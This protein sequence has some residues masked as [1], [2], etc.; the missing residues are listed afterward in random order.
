MNDNDLLVDIYYNKKNYDGLENLYKKAKITNKNITRAF[1]KEWL[2]KQS[3][4]QESNKHAKKKIFLPIYSETPF[5]FQIDLTFFPRYKKQ[6]YN[7]YVLFTAININTRYAYAYYSK[8]KDMEAVLDMMKQF[9]RDALEINAITTDE[10]REFNNNEFL[11][12]C[13]EQDIDVF[14]VK[15]DSHKLGIVNRFHR[16]LKNKLLKHF[17][18]NDTVN[19]VDVIKDVIYNYNHTVN[20]GIG[21]EPYKVNSFIEAEIVAEKKEKTDLINENNLSINIGDKCRIK[22]KDVLFEDKMTTKYSKTVYTIMKVNKNSVEIT[23]NDDDLTV[24]KT[25]IMIVKDNIEH[26]APNTHQVAVQIQAKQN[27]KNAR[28]QVDVNDIRAPRG[29]QRKQRVLMNLDL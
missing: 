24:K 2:Y 21:I 6:N 10:G 4:H 20:T 14:F 28:A 27:N 25:D 22:K 29:T 18:A 17:T 23:H 9:K 16:T 19:W 11:E 26:I 7:I 13:Q 15:G 8:S 5:A 12:Y 1:V 3:T